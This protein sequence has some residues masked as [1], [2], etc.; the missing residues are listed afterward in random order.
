M[1]SVKP[2][3]LFV[4]A[5][6]AQ[7]DAGLRAIETIT[8]SA[9]RMHQAQLE[10]ATEAHADA[11]ATRKAIAAASD[12]SQIMKLSAEWTR[13]NAGKSFA[14]WRSLLQAG[15]PQAMAGMP[16]LEML[17]GA[18]QQWLDSVQRLYKPAERP[19]V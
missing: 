8:E 4:Q 16:R 2:E 18:Y 14:Y 7:L 3:D 1:R 17:N 10:A 11:V 9:I 12:A 19:S 13:E 5:W 15:T 6:K